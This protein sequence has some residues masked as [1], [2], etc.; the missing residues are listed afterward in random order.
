MDNGFLMIV[1]RLIHIIS[2]VFWGGAAIS[3]SWFLLPAQRS[4]G[5]PGMA[6]MR[7]LMFGKRFRAAILAAM[8]LTLLSGVTMYVWLG[9]ETHWEWTKTPM[10]RVL[11]VGAIAAIIAGII[12]SH[13]VGGLTKKAIALGTTIESSGSHATDAQKAEMGVLQSKVFRAYRITAILILIAVAAM[14]MGRYV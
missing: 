1:L 6:F 8:V 2:G 10:A 14:A 3:L 12:G 11:G 9:M 4:L 5:Q 13:Y 7:E